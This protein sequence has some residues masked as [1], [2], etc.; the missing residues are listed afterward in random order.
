MTVGFLLLVV[1]FA[2]FLGWIGGI[3]KQGQMAHKTNDLPD[4]HFKVISTDKISTVLEHI[5]PGGKRYLIT[6]EVFGGKPIRPKEVV[7]RIKDNKEYKTFQQSKLGYPPL[8][9]E[10][11]I[12]EIRGIDD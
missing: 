8:V 2:A 7:R 10:E 1:A 11:K 12:L 3:T 5:K 9:K 4:G 6:T